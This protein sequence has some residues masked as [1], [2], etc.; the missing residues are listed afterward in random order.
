MNRALPNP[1][2]GSWGLYQLHLIIAL[3]PGNLNVP[4]FEIASPR[5]Q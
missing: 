4:V 3:S 5:S 1:Y 2:M